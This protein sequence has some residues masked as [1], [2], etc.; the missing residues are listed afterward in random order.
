[1]S[2]FNRTNPF[3]ALGPTGNM[4]YEEMAR[5]AMA[6]GYRVNGNEAV[7][8]RNNTGPGFDTR[9]SAPV[10]SFGNAPKSFL[11][12]AASLL[13][14]EYEAKQGAADR[15]FDR[16]AAATG[17][18][19]DTIGRG[20]GQ[21]QTGLNTSLSEIDRI[22]G[23]TQSMQNRFENQN[24]A[25]IGD[26]VGVA[27]KAVS[28]FNA[29]TDKYVKQ[30]VNDMRSSAD[31][32]VS[33]AKDAVGSYNT[34]VT[35]NAIQATVAG[36]RAD[37]RNQKAMIQK[38]L[39][40]DGT[41]MTMAERNEAANSLQKTTGLQIAQ[42][43]ATVREQAQKTLA[44]LKMGLSSTILGAGQ[45]K[46]EAAKLGMAG[47]QSKLEAEQTR[48]GARST[49]IQ[50]MLATQEGAR[51]FQSMLSGLVQFGAQLRSATDSASLQYEMQG[52]QYMAD[53]I[54]QNPE[55]IMG[56]LSGL[57]SLATIGTAPGGANLR[58]L[59]F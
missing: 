23:T 17:T 24:M 14:W 40:P 18:I 27:D 56:V 8:W 2:S 57:M 34:G 25:A 30:G 11:D 15:Q 4:P 38:G 5:R 35:E 32:A 13:K 22:A 26:L 46:G 43:V 19:G 51:Q 20:M 44:S 7:M 48:V 42:T 37:Y 6:Q 58:A 16:N 1:M 47:E 49:A 36:M 29:G 33:T 41:L 12:Q 39:N 3:D 50:G 55:T 28:S 59:Q 52:R 53:A 54:R 21:F 9:I 45:L 31:A 10:S